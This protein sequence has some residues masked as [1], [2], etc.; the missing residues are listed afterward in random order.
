MSNLRVAVRHHDIV[1]TKPGTDFSLTFR[2]DPLS[3]MLEMV[4]SIPDR[5]NHRLSAFLACGWKAAYSKAK[6]LDWL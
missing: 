6:E 2:K 5:L 4:G 3:P 1:V